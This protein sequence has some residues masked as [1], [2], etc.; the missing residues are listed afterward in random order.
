MSSKHVRRSGHPGIE[1]IDLA[2]EPTGPPGTLPEDTPDRDPAGAKRRL[3][4]PRLKITGAAVAAVAALLVAWQLIP[5]APATHDA[6]KPVPPAARRAP[7]GA[8]RPGTRNTRP[9]PSTNASIRATTE[10]G[11]HA[12][13]LGGT[14]GDCDLTALR[15]DYPDASAT[16]TRIRSALVDQI[17]PRDK[18]VESP[19]GQANCLWPDGSDHRELQTV[20]TWT[21]GS[22]QGLIIINVANFDDPAMTGCGIGW[23]CAPAST[24]HLHA[25]SAGVI[26]DTGDRGFGVVVQRK[27]GQYVSIQA[28][29]QPLIDNDIDPARSLNHFPF[30]AKKLLPV[31]VDPRVHLDRT[32][33][34]PH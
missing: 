17:D 10:T 29:A 27:D 5:D 3:R 16:A 28:G 31:A 7:V 26:R 6:N 32:I 34:P 9:D 13:S 12:G 1:L 23:S 15:A 2:D 8:A 11:T 14:A 21:S 19:A 20:L 33:A 25:R 24:K 18:H 4:N 22:Y 30:G